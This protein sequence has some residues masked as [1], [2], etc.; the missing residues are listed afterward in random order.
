MDGATT[1]LLIQGGITFTVGLVGVA[2]GFGTLRAHVKRLCS[3][4][5]ELKRKHAG[6]TN[7]VRWYLTAKEGLSVSEIA[8]I[9]N[10][11]T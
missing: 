4:V 5:A 8:E 6:V 9:L 2:V 1:G 11:G 10:G 7:A 3:D